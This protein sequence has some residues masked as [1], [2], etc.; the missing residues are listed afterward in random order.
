MAEAFAKLKGLQLSPQK[1]RLVAN[2]VRGLPIDK[3]LECLSFSP[4][5]AARFIK[6]TLESAIS[7]AENNLGLDIDTLKI[8]GIYVDEAKISKRWMARAKGRVNHIMKRSC[9][10]TIKLS[11]VTQ[12]RKK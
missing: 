1:C 3:A 8:S 5:K 10:L 6:K 2:Q 7:N 12:V 11:P 9:H 4:K